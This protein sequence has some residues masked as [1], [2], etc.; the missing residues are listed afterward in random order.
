MHILSVADVHC[1]STRSMKPTQASYRSNISHSPGSRME[2]AVHS[3][4]CL[5]QNWLHRHERK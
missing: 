1:V 2:G 5:L 4:A 3:V